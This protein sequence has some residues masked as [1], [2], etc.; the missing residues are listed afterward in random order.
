MKKALTTE[1]IIRG[2]IVFALIAFASTKYELGNI[3]QGLLII[4][5]MTLLG[6]SFI[7]LYQEYLYYSKKKTWELS[8]KKTATMVVSSILIPILFIIVLPPN[9]KLYALLVVGIVLLILV[10]YYLIN[11]LCN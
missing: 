2:S 4:L 7:R 6:A 11:K 3:I 10:I 5:A 8:S 9:L 1:N